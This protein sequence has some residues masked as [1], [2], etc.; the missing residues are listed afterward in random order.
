MSAHTCERLVR[1]CERPQPQAVPTSV[2]ADRRKVREH[3]GRC[4]ALARAYAELSQ[5][6][7]AQQL[8]MIG[9][10]AARRRGSSS[11]LAN[12]CLVKAHRRNPLVLQVPGG[13][14]RL[15]DYKQKKDH[16]VLLL[17]RDDET[18]PDPAMLN[19]KTAA[20]KK[21]VVEDESEWAHSA[22]VCV[23]YEVTGSKDYPVVL[24]HVPTLSRLAVEDFLRRCFRM[25]LVRGAGPN[26]EAV[27][28]TVELLVDQSTQVRDALKTGKLSGVKFLR[29]T[30][31]PNLGIGEEDLENT[32]AMQSFKPPKE[33]RVAFERKDKEE[34]LKHWLGIARD[35]GFED[36]RLEFSKSDDYPDLP[37]SIP[38]PTHN[39]DTSADE[40]F[41]TRRSSND[42]GYKMDTAYGKCQPD[43]MKFGHECLVNQYTRVK[44]RHRRKRP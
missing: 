42:F 26:G 34:L 7:V 19:K 1:T 5:A 11:T 43:V 22:H 35:R 39:P 33:I 30:P 44:N 15:M 13:S 17:V 2:T 20:I 29:Y 18:I 10:R 12:R 28:P 25:H 41:F 21:V 9:T 38:I 32:G 6:E 27:Y 4:F 8:G 3:L 37:T 14:V 24:E 40:I 16:A 31:D 23:G 36:V